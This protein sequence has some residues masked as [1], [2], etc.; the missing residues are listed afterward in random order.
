MGYKVYTLF[1]IIYF[2]GL[3]IVLTEKLNGIDIIA[4]KKLTMV[5]LIQTIL[6]FGLPFLMCIF[7]QDYKEPLPAEVYMALF[8]LFNF[9]FLPISTVSTLMYKHLFLNLKINRLSKLL[10]CI[11]TFVPIFD[12]IILLI[13]RARG[14]YN[15]L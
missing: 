10:V 3:T 8:I 6:I 15:N 5:K 1:I 9:I 12:L 2:I 13:L 11:A 7:A 14:D 4:L